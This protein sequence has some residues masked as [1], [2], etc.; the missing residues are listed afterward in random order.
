M[1]NTNPIFLDSSVYLTQPE[2]FQMKIEVS[3]CFLEYENKI[4]LLHRQD[5]TSEGNLWGIPGGKVE[6]HETPFEAILR[7]LLEEISLEISTQSLSYL[8]KVYIKFPTYDFIYHMFKCK[9]TD[10]PDKMQISFDEH[11]GFTWVTPED[12][13][14]MNLM[15]EEDAC[16]KLIYGD[17]SLL[18][19]QLEFCNLT[20]LNGS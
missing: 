19:A 3:A 15:L 6:K 2:N 11:K 12:A 20:K 14:K 5:H 18:G 7:E 16:I 9:L 13:L 10:R 17:D 4:L 8:G 1:N